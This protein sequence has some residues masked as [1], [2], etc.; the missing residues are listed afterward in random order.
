MEP[1]V[2]IIGGGMTGLCI[3][4]GLE[5]TG[6]KHTIFDSEDGVKF[7]P[8]EWTMGIHWGLPLLESLLPPH[9]AKR[10]PTDGSVDGFLDY[11]LLVCFHLLINFFG[12]EQHHE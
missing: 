1:N 6:I 5:Q 8:K 3:A 7:R 10:I 11:Y 9:L 2:L 12:I 4:H